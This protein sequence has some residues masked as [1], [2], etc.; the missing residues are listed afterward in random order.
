MHKSIIQRLCQV[1]LGP[2]PGMHNTCSGYFRNGSRS[3]CNYPLIQLSV[4]TDQRTHWYRE[5]LHADTMSLQR[6][7]QVTPIPVR[8]LMTTCRFD[9]KRLCV[10][11]L[12]RSVLLVGQDVP[13]STLSLLTILTSTRRRIPVHQRHLVTEQPDVKFS[14]LQTRSYSQSD[15]QAHL[16]TDVSSEK[17]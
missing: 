14:P 5:R 4:R 3:T 13:M 11:L 12:M 7:S 15:V 8:S 10:L 16:Y 17:Q 1:I 2:T 6:R 9:A